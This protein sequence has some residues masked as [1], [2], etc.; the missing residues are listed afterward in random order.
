MDIN[1]FQ[2]RYQLEHKLLPHWI[3]TEEPY[4]VLRALFKG[5][6]Q[7]FI[8]QMNNIG[9]GRHKETFSPMHSA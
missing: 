6:G 2:I 5:K 7:F 8:H 3:F 4:S 9:E 1:T